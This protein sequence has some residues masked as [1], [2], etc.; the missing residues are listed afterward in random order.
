[1][2][3]MNVDKEKA[4]TVKAE[5]ENDK[6]NAKS[7]V[8]DI[9]ANGSKAKQFGNV[10]PIDAAMNDADDVH[11]AKW[12]VADDGSMSFD[13]N[14]NTRFIRRA[15][16]VY[17]VK[18]VK[19]EWTVPRRICGPLG[20]V[21]VAAT[22]ESQNW[23]LKLFWKDKRNVH[24]SLT[25]PQGD[26]AEGKKVIRILLDG[27][28]DVDALSAQNGNADIVL[29]LLKH[30]VEKWL[31][32]IDR[33]GWSESGKWLILQTGETVG[34]PEEEILFTRND[35]DAPLYE[36][37][38]TL[39]EWQE[40]VAMPSTRSSRIAFAIC[41][42]FAPLLLKFVSACEGGFHFVGVTGSGKSSGLRAGVSV[43]S[44]AE[45]S[46]TGCELSSWKNTTTGVETFADKRSGWPMFIDE[47][48]VAETNA[49]K[50]LPAMIY[51]LVNGQGKRRSNRALQAV[52]PMSWSAFFLS[53]GEVTLEDL[54]AR[55]NVPVDGGVRVRLANIPAVPSNV[56]E[57]VC[58]F[59]QPGEDWMKVVSKISEAASRECY[60]TA[61]PE[62]ARR[63]V[64][65]IEEHG[66]VEAFSTA[67]SG[68]VE[69]W[70]SRKAENAIQQVRRVGRRFALVAVAGEL[71][72]ELGILPWRKGE[73]SKFVEIC[74]EDWRREYEAAES[75]NDLLGVPEALF[76][77]LP[78]QF[79][80]AYENGTEIAISSTRAPFLGYAVLVKKDGELSRLF[81][82]PC[83]FDEEVRKRG[84]SGREIV[85]AFR[86]A[87]R[88]Y[89]EK[90][91]GKRRLKT[92]IARPQW[93]SMSNGP[94]YALAATLEAMKRFEEDRK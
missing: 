76:H 91:D 94:F 42:A 86:D 70:I 50:N 16:G 45:Q 10:D 62:F 64:A 34:T 26:L 89:N 93:K 79:S 32:S 40:K 3:P 33:A 75:E 11:M 77:T 72:I 7:I 22:K 49:V 15:L 23:M 63:L 39:E 4:P 13:A 83:G 56:R 82:N 81:I 1:M 69:G 6:F 90:K 65:Y 88:L 19:D 47:L 60:G 80:V 20:V 44:F 24:H 5:A 48:G 36:A 87:G 61:G 78:D 31:L 38:G 53:T 2:S 54:A 25:I 35:E 14:E 74:F 17:V 30:P 43:W 67:L 18:R 59:L 58:D 52:R 41:A 57:G 71:A 85:R 27:G 37:K 29:Y 55:Q 8:K 66:G 28:L 46:R 9:A 73:A 51:M 84:K 12:V 92:R 21:A 68:R